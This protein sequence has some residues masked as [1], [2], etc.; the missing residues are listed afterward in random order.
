MREIV[1]HR[2]TQIEAGT[3]G[4]LMV[5]TTLPICNTLELPW[6]NNKP[7]LSCPPLGSWVMNRFQSPK[8]GDVFEI[9][10]KGRDKLLLHWGNTVVDN[11]N[12]EKN[13]KQSDGCVILGEGIDPVNDGYGVTNSKAAFQEFMGRLKGVTQARLTITASQ[14]L[15]D[16][17]YKEASQ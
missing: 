15:M 8:Y 11:P 16:T 13:E 10:C 6:L 4:L 7:F 5:D 2:V 9:I 14:Y 1:I 3:F 12:T 17:I